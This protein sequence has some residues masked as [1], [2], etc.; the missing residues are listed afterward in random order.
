MR[1]TLLALSLT[2]LAIGGVVLAGCP[3]VAAGGAI[4][5]EGS[6]GVEAT[7]VCICKC[8]LSKDAPLAG[9]CLGGGGGMGGM[10]GAGEGA[11]GGRCDCVIY[12]QLNSYV[13]SFPKML[14]FVSGGKLCLHIAVSVLQ[15]KTVLKLF[16]Y[17]D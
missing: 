6:Q 11:I 2:E 15:F 5:V 17:E 3:E 10:R 14:Y 4:T 16:T 8:L 7:C 13:L 12:I 9:V 1:P